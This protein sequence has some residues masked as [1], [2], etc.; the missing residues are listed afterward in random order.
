MFETIFQQF[1]YYSQFSNIHEISEPI[2]IE[3]QDCNTINFY[4]DLSTC[5]QDFKNKSWHWNYYLH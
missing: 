5:L 3:N 2:N 1:S 4:D